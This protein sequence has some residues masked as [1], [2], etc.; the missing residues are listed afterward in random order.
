MDIDT[1][2]FADIRPYHDHEVR[3]VLDSLIED[4][5]FI[6]AI[7]NLRI[8]RQTKLMKAL[9]YPFVR[10][11]IRRMLKGVHDIEGI[12]DI[13]KVF[14]DRM[15]AKTSTSFT[16]SGLEQLDKDRNYLFIGNH[17]D[18]VLD[19]AL[20]N[21]ALKTCGYPTV[22]IAIGDNLQSKSFISDLMRLNKSFIV[23]R[24][25]KGPREKVHALRRLSKYICHSVHKDHSNI[26]IAQGEGRA[27]DG[28]DVTQPAIIKMLAMSKPKEQDF[29]SYIRS[30]S[31]VPVAI[32]YELDPCDA[33]KARELFL[34]ETTGSYQK[35]ATEDFESISRGIKGN[36]GG[37][38]LSFGT[39]MDQDYADAE[40]VAHEIDR[41]ITSIYYTHDSNRICYQLK[42]KGNINEDISTSKRNSFENRLTLIPNQYRSYAID[43]Y[44]NVVERKLSQGVTEEGSLTNLTGNN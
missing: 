42:T 17:R 14:L 28:R 39:V 18:I 11:R 23:K 41:Q 31:I 8:R 13:V 6:S 43:M 35:R 1:D 9:A 44:A 38:H 10:Q 21:Y 3:E 12:Q 20:V 2:E 32:S 30:L 26:W 4:D 15:L 24:S 34:R 36:K 29:N 40:E 5:E 7:I 22:R 19:P 27:K 33:N 16:I 37:I 25:I